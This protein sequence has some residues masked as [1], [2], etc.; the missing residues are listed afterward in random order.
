MTDATEQFRQFI[1]ATCNTDPGHIVADGR[2]HRFNISDTRSKSSKPGRY[3]LHNDER[4][5]G[6]FMDWRDEKT[7]HR[8]FSDAQPISYDREA[9]A[10]KRAARTAELKA[11]FDAAAVAA[12]AWWDGAVNGADAASHPYIERKG[13]KTHGTR[14]RKH[15]LLVPLYN[16]DGEFRTLQ[17]ISGDGKRLFWKGTQVEGGH[18]PIG[19]FETG[20]IVLCEGFSTGAS[21]HEA[22]GY[23]VVVCID[24]GNM[25]AVARW[26]GHRWAGRDFIVAADDDWHLPL[27]DPP[28][29]NKGRVSGES[30][31]RILGA[32]LVVASL[33]GLESDGGDDFNDVAREYDLQTV[34][35]QFEAGAM[36]DPLPIEVVPELTAPDVETA[37][38]NPLAIIDPANWSGEAIPVRKWRLEGLIPEGQ[39]T[40]LTGAGAAGK[41][42][43]SQQLATCIAMGIPFIGTQVHQSPALYI[44]CEDDAEELHRRQ[45]SICVSLGIGMDELRGRLMLL[46]LQGEIGNE[47][48][49]FDQ[50]GEMK[51]AKRYNQIVQACQERGVSFC[52]LDNTAHL[53]TGN[54]NDRH[55]VASFINLSNRMANEIGGSTV[56]V[57]HPNKAGDSYSGSTA[58]EN[59]VR[60]R[61]FLE[62]PK[63]EE[64]APINPDMRVLRNEKANYARRGAELFFQWH[65]GAFVDPRTIP[66]TERGPSAN[67]LIGAQ[68]E[69]TFLQLLDILTD[70][71]RHVSHASNGQYAP[72][73]MARMPQANGISQGRLAKA[74]ERLFA[75][76]EIQAS[77][78]L[79]KGRDRH[80]V[81][82]I[83]RRRVI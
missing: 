65:E 60:S 77:Q 49:T 55:Q 13:I 66:E 20:P 29:P 68:D 71:K 46:S 1:I 57:G 34:V 75:S 72:R 12:K 6:L 48:A 82:G 32:R 41:S 59:Q 2:W 80:P 3:L 79:W 62:T 19:D 51:I 69:E 44:T 42:L 70:D 4:P 25:V 76:K 64:G 23:P 54:E 11:Q 26:A 43:A 74:M 14:V 37:P 15:G 33:L 53:F 9:V 83:A 47:L 52:V 30:A 10:A 31:A 16:A 21:I 81:I 38:T 24:A 67:D 22:T 45:A 8:W 56:I 18:F 35:D 36:S 39:A 27:Q 7:R 28:K 40:L 58:W 61:L 78:E 63:D 17:Q 50:A 73:V 5:V